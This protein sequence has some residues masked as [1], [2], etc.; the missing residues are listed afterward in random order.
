MC[1]N[2]ANL[3]LRVVLL[4]IGLTVGSCSALHA[5]DKPEQ[6]A[7]P[8]LFERDV[9]PIVSAYCW[10]CHGGE[11]RK[12][13]LDLRTLPLM[14]KGG[15]SGPAVVRGSAAESL[16]FQKLAK[17]QMPPGDMLK[18]SEQHVRTIGAWLEAGAP[19]RYEGGLSEFE[20]PPLTEQDQNWWAFCKP[21][22]H[23]PPAVETS[24]LVRTPVDCFLLSK[25][26]SKRL[27]FSQAAEPVALV[28]RIFFDLIGLPP[29]PREVDAYFAEPRPD[30]YQRLV[31]RLLASPAYGE[32]WGRHWLDAAGYADVGGRDQN[33]DGYS[34]FDG[35]WR[36]R[37][38]V[39]NS[40]NEDK[41]FDRFL[42]EQL[43][44]DELVPWRNTDHYTPEVEEMLVATGFLRLEADVTRTALMN[45]M[46][47]E[48]YQTINVMLNL[49]GS[50]LLGLTIQCARCHNHKY[51]PISQL[52]YYRLQAIFSP[53]YNPQHWLY[54]PMENGKDTPESAQRYLRDTSEEELSIMAAENENIDSEVAAISKRIAG[55]RK[56][57]KSTILAAKIARL[58]EPIREDTK[59][60]LA[61]AA[62]NRNPIQK[63]LAEK[64]ESSL[65]V[66]EDEISQALSESAQRTIAELQEK[67]ATLENGKRTAGKIQALWDVGPP[68]PQYVLRRG[69]WQ[70]P[71]AE[72]TP[73]V[74]AV[75]EDPQQPFTIPAAKPGSGTSGYRT[76]LARWLTQR[77]TVASG[78]VSR[79]FINR[80]WQHYFGRG[81]VS[82]T[83]N[84]GRNGAP[85][86][87]PELLDWLVTEWV[88]G[89]WKVKRIHRMIVTST[90]Y[91]Q[92][93]F[94]VQK[95]D[96]EVRI[97]ESSNLHSDLRVSHSKQTPY[98]MD[99]ENKLLS[100]M[101][102][103]RLESEA[104]RDAMLAASGCLDRTMGG[105]PLLLKIRLPEGVVVI[106]TEKLPDPPSPHRRS[107]YVLS[108]RNFHLAI[109]NVFDQPTLATNCTH[110]KSSEVVQQSLS[111]LN[112]D[113]VQ[114]Q[115]RR[116]AQRVM[117]D[118]VASQ[119]PRIEVAFRIALNR[120]PT[121]HEIKLA[122][123]LLEDHISL[124]RRRKP[125]LSD[126][127]LAD[128][129]LVD[130]CHMLLNTNEFLY[131]E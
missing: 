52:D 14:L 105:P 1:A 36:Y 54:G 74:F 120:R 123:E 44:G 81:I 109:L 129:A 39:I 48:Q 101:P 49:V 113:F 96:D 78:L 46:E 91:R 64:F 75:L 51:D 97:E 10:N 55:L 99:P 47:E 27:S 111:M 87:H 9:V 112:G 21:V 127:Q 33:P 106:D 88:R 80:V 58:P 110:R 124:D 117:S 53:A 108:R 121:A 63:Y 76:A 66:T 32:R 24:R 77:D 92:T 57:T 37:D 82:T 90:A 93:S 35:I 98:S 16:L 2:F 18:P 61:T 22:R 8:L 30:K 103:R 122:S 72:V 5:E 40:L 102:L 115:A 15:K 130:L 114:E 11:H 45:M 126:Q 26:Q 67:V 17:A 62:D 56:E 131:L 94:R 128:K 85:P 23:R 73:G 65:K 3:G 13:D 69:N 86:T 12:A 19:A 79:V 42:T 125:Q 116:F 59:N 84:F 28:R 34:V 68:T 50:N 38:Y 119:Q 95:S 104:I 100:W 41:P 31:D 4:V 20:A 107:I 118:A 29:T 89:G 43:A 7:I 6:S 83:D 70:T 71:G 25:L 60:A